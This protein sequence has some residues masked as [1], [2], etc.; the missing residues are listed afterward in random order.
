MFFLYEAN[1]NYLQDSLFATVYFF[2]FRSDLYAIAE[3][4]H[5]GAYRKLGEK[6]G[7]TKAK[8]ERWGKDHDES[9]LKATY[10]MLCDRLG[11]MS[12]TQWMSTL[13]TACD[14]CGLKK[15]S[16]HLKE[17][18]VSP[19]PTPLQKIASKSDHAFYSASQ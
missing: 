17:G 3:S 5:P 12:D 19:H 14:Q 18:Q 13:M 11:N 6:L 15:I 7:Y 1:A 4:I 10:S 9:I 8:L 16:L 2:I